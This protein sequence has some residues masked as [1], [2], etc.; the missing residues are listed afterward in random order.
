M[1]NAIGKYFRAIWYLMTFRVN[2]ASETLRMNPGVISA[3]YDRIIAEK[4]ARLNQYKDAISAMIAQEESKKAK[5]KQLTEEIEKLEK[6][7][8]GAAAKAKKIVEKYQGNAEAVKADPDYIKCQAAFK[9]FS[10]TLAEKQQRAQELEEDLKQLVANVNGHKTQIQS[11]MRD[12]EKLKEE[13]HDAVAEVLSANEEKQ[14]AD[15][16]TGL[17]NDRTS[18]EL[19]ELRELRQKASASARISRELAGLDTERAEEEFIQYAT[20]SEADDEFDA[21][22]GLTKQ[23]SEQPLPPDDTRIPE[24]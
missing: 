19:R 5:L 24:A 20:A 10:S 23:E 4:K 6:L 9:D 1:F 18:E 11:L 13:K 3:N 12:L 22:I 17:S 21:L 15:I 7:R 14:I 2:K 8:A 16:V